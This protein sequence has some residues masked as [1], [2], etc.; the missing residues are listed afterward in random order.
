MTTTHHPRH[1]F[2]T[3][4][5]P[6]MPKPPSCPPCNNNMHPKTSMPPPKMMTTTTAPRHFNHHV[7]SGMPMM[8]TKESFTGPNNGCSNCLMV[9]KSADVQALGEPMSPCMNCT[10]IY[11]AMRDRSPYDRAYLNAYN[12]LPGMYVTNLDSLVF[13]P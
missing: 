5:M 9:P 12:K 8:H 4:S 13:A 11:M 10:S 7:S 1:H 6:P 2:R 3:T